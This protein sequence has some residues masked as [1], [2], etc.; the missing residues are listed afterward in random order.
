MENTIT[1]F[2]KYQEA[3]GGLIS[4]EK[5]DE[6]LIS[7]HSITE[8]EKEALILYHSRLAFKVA[9]QYIQK[10]PDKD[11]SEL[12]STTLYG[13][14]K[15]LDTFDPNRGFCFSSY[16]MR[17]IENEVLMY[18]R[19][20]K[21]QRSE[22]STEEFVHVDGEGNE[23]K[24]EDILP[25]ETEDV[26]R[27]LTVYQMNQEVHICMTHLPF[28]EQEVL[29][30]HLGLNDEKRVLTQR[31]ISKRYSLSQSYI[32][33]LIKTALLRLV[34]LYEARD[35]VIQT[36]FQKKRLEA[37]YYRHYY[38]FNELEQTILELFY[39]F[40]GRTTFSLSELAS[41]LDKKWNFVFD[42]LKR[43]HSYMMELEVL[44]CYEF[45]EKQR[46]L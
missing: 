1:T 17:C 36:P 25:A 8:E 35:M 23:L 21:H 19:K 28:K 30:D 16:A 24:I 18:L 10:N 20:T 6:Y 40:D 9:L 22:V 29:K 4:K 38:E 37:V 46:K 41:M 43:L 14:I 2:K 39:G 15:G 26:A 33:R 12:F 45:N 31:E 5:A 27:N 13:L 11:E 3:R 42:T 44:E 7:Y 32:S 34:K